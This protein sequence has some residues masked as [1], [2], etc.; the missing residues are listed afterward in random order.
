[1][2]T[3]R[4][5]VDLLGSRAVAVDGDIGVEVTGVAY[6]SRR[7]EPGF[8]FVAVP[9]FVHDGAKFIPEAV[10]RGATAVVTEREIAASATGLQ[11]TVRV[12]SARRTLA[13]LAARWY[14]NPSQQLNVAGVTG[15]NGKTTVTA[16]LEGMF[17]DEAPSGRWSTT[18]VRIAGRS[19]PTPRTTPEAIELQAALSEMLEAGC[20]NVVIEVSSHAL[21]LHRTDQTRFAAATFTNLSPDHLDFHR[22]M[23]DYFD[24]KAGLFEGLAADAPAIINLSD[25]Y[26]RRLAGRSAGRVVGYGWEDVAN[27]TY[28]ILEFDSS[29]AGSLLTLDTPAGRLALR[30]PLFG[31]ANAENLAAAV[32]TATELGASA[33]RVEAVAAGFRGEAGRLQMLEN[34]G[35]FSVLVD[36]AHTP[37]AL[38]AALEA[39]RS[40]VDDGRVIVVF[41]RGGDRDRNKRPMM[42]TVAVNAA[43]EVI[44]TSDNPRSEDPEAIIEDILSGIAASER[45]RVVV[46]SER[47]PA[48]RRAV[49]DARPGDCVLIAGKGHETV[50]IFAEH[51]VPFDDVRVATQAL[52]QVGGDS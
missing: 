3:T 23:E 29:P 22:D 12:D 49:T 7:V 28:R 51:T 8:V 21:R 48:I 5:L 47:A 10:A 2:E 13:A 42:G 24:A 27:A 33:G 40:I 37:G 50:Q 1:M 20:R 39:A 32:A 38:E 19:A 17:T 18:Q 43:D 15:T 6:D 9:G 31:R 52:R 41:G 34:G 4:R 16:L 26:G 45:S 30:T 14:D 35:E 11:C 25:P 46:E 44:V 36:F